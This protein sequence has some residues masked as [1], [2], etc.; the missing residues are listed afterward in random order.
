MKPQSLLFGTTAMAMA[1]ALRVIVQVISLPI[2]GR[3][4]GP[5][6]YGQLA[7]VTP[8]IYFSMLIAESG[9]SAC[10]V[11]AK[12]VTKTL[13]G[14]IFC[15]SAGFSLLI[16]AVFAALA[17]PL[18]HLLGEPLFPPLL[19]AMSNMLLLA[20]FNV[21]PEGLLLRARRYDWLALSDV[22]STFGAV[23]AVT[24]GILLNWGTW[25]LVAQDLTFWLCKV[26]IVTL[27]SRH[28]P[29]FLF[30]WQ[31][32]KENISFGANLTGTSLL[33]FI[34]RNIDNI[35]IAAF[36]GAQVLG[37]YALAFQATGLPQMILS[38][39]VYF[40]LFSVTD[41]AVR[42]GKPT[43]PQFLKMLRGV[44]LVSAPAMIGMAV[45]SP[46]SVPL[47]LGEKWQ[48]MI[49]IL[50]LL[51]P[52]GLTQVIGFTTSGVLVGLGRTNIMFRLALVTTCVTVVAILAGVRVG[53]GAVG[54]GVSLA[55]VLNCYMGLKIVAKEC[56]FKFYKIVE[57]M[58]AP[59]IASCVMGAAVLSL[60]YFMPGSLLTV[61]RLAFSVITGI[62]VYAFMML[63]VFRDHLATDIA[64]IKA[65]ISARSLRQH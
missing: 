25:S 53:I 7:L 44:M 20:A 31:I 27:G 47:L 4:L 36:M 52:L 64:D 37:Y 59:L 40:T 45:T 41:E 32:I 33:T 51:T 56:D 5:H 18:G 8:F 22:I 49:P 54:L 12:E 3:I 35:L 9:L 17:Y 13:Q 19:I 23:T 28:R 38:G 15:F 2:L 62:L 6:S 46:L 30:Q 39:S 55:A 34:A 14:T 57:T 63:I 10:I 65:I 1:R 16:M 29:R 21:V 58:M 24:I 26:C 11:R 50:F 61:M 60:Q 43:Y 48:P 42:A